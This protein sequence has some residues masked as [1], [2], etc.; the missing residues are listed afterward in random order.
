MLI[1]QRIE[2]NL[3]YRSRFKSVLSGIKCLNVHQRFLSRV[4]I[5]Y[6]TLLYSAINPYFKERAYYIRLIPHPKFQGVSS[7]PPFSN[8]LEKLLWT[9]SFFWII[10]LNLLSGDR[11]SSLLPM[12]PVMLPF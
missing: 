6:F 3:I 8:A 2:C 9:P 11:S 12:P 5:S 1:H 10:V 4:T 7:P